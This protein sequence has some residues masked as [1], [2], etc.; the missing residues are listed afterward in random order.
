[1]KT[2]AMA[3]VLQG[4]NALRIFLRIFAHFSHFLAFLGKMR[5]FR[6]FCAFSAFFLK[7]GRVVGLK[8]KPAGKYAA[9][10]GPKSHQNMASRV[11]KMI[12]NVCWTQK[13]MLF[14]HNFILR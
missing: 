5:I 14:Y 7:I 11:L 1:M 4:G 12:R 6:I 8:G 2:M 9:I 3:W 13:M 10:S